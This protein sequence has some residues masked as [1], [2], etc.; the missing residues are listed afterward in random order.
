MKRDKKFEA[1]VKTARALPL[2]A[3]NQVLVKVTGCGI[4][5]SYKNHGDRVKTT[6]ASY[7]LLETVPMHGCEP[8]RLAFGEEHDTEMLAR[9]WMADWSAKLTGNSHCKLEDLKNITIVA[10]LDKQ[11]GKNAM[12]IL[13]NVAH[14][15]DR[16]AKAVVW[17]ENVDALLNSRYLD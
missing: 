4:A 14:N 9:K 5:D 15:T 16:A 12:D 3:E 8:I 1:R 13:S 10:T 6:Y 2:L 11:Y 7:M 17:I